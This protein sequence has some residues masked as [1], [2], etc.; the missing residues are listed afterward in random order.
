MGLEHSFYEAEQL[1]A[2]EAL[3]EEA[4]ANL[5]WQLSQ[6]WSLSASQSENLE[7][8]SRVKSEAAFLYEDD[9][10]IFQI[11]MERDYSSVVGTS[12]EPE[13]SVN[14]TFT[15]KTLTN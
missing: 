12:I 5:D 2:G 9:C 6:N 15:L 3:L 11:T 7:T 13:T 1:G 4:S 14:F 8:K 10:T